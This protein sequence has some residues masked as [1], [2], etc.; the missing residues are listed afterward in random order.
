MKKTRKPKGF[1]KIRTESMTYSQRCAIAISEIRA[2][3]ERA[4]VDAI[5]S[6]PSLWASPMPYTGERFITAKPERVEEA[7]ALLKRTAYG[8]LGKEV[9][10][11]SKKFGLGISGS[12]GSGSNA[13]WHDRGGVFDLGGF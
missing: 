7:R 8:S 6:Q 5:N 2:V 9:R 13:F 10:A 11:I 1:G 12:V 4:L 3:F